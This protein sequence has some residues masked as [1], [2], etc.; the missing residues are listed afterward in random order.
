MRLPNT[1][2]HTLVSALEHQFD[3][4]S[5][6][7]RAVTLDSL[8]Q[9][10]AD[11]SCFP[12]IFLKIMTHSLQFTYASG[13]LSDFLVRW[14]PCQRCPQRLLR[15]YCKASLGCFSS[16]NYRFSTL[17]Q[18]RSYICILQIHLRRVRLNHRI[19]W[20]SFQQESLPSG[21]LKIGTRGPK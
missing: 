16:P 11:T 10:G 2:A 7:K 15:V 19:V 13:V 21:C 8:D 14:W 3:S 4:P 5:E 9:F 12:H 6:K 17:Q 20:W 1:S 18:C